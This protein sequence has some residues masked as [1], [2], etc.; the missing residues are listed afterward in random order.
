MKI[1]GTDTPRK[2]AL[3]K[4]GFGPQKQG[5]TSTKICAFCTINS[6]TTSHHYTK[7]NTSTDT[8]LQNLYS[9]HVSLHKNLNLNPSFCRRST[10]RGA[11]PPFF[12]LAPT[13]QYVSDFLSTRFVSRSETAIF[14]ILCFRF[15]PYCCRSPQQSWA[16]PPSNGHP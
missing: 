12:A 4:G 13:E 7:I 2:I 8:S 15:T 10:Y 11:V 6:V 1:E 14:P 5:G 16:V 9:P 3:K